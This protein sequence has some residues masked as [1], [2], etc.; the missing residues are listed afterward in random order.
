MNWTQT[1]VPAAV[2][3]V[4]LGTTVIAAALEARIERF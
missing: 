4:M 3:A 1:V 2:G